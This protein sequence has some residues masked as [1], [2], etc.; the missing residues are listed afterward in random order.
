MKAVARS[1]FQN[2]VGERTVSLDCFDRDTRRT[3]NPYS[4]EYRI[5][6]TTLNGWRRYGEGQKE[7]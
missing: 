5:L 4:V 7:W 2:L 1:T 6:M 3:S